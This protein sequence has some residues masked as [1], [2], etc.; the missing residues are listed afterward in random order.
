MY[1]YGRST[2]QALT[3]TTVRSS[4][5]PYHHEVLVHVRSLS[6]DNLASV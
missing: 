2:L 6:L 3:C 1:R 5:R 4:Y